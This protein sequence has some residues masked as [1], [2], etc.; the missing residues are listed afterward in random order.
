MRLLAAAERIVSE[1]GADAL[2][3]E[4]VCSLSGVSRA[5]FRLCFDGRAGLLLALHDE[6][7]SRASL[8]MGRAYLAQS[9][10]VDGVR[11]AIT[12]LL[13]ILERDVSLAR[14]MMLDSAIDESPLPS[15]RA[16][17][18][19]DFAAA[20]ER[21]RPGLPGTYGEPPFGA[22]ALIGA[23]ASILHGRLM[24]DPLPS[25]TDLSGGLTAMIVLPY[26]GA[27][28]AREELTR[29]SVAPL[30]TPVPACAP[31]PPRL[32]LRTVAML[33]AIE[34]RPGSSNAELARAA[35]IADP[36]QVS[37]LLSRLRSRGLVEREPPVEGRQAA[38]GWR[39]SG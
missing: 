7:A 34:A 21:E 24:E 22:R 11:A 6:L 2:T 30:P 18:L 13:A 8:A 15:R 38:K 26:L 12:E 16:R 25:L 29:S 4:S 33:R 20:L 31:T 17:L 27:E 35:A 28:A 10:W 3:V 37:R 14:F 23:V 39:L 1:Q 32:T 9:S 5:G 19:D 36:G